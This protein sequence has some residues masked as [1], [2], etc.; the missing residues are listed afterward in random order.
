MII[1]TRLKGKFTLCL[2]R[3]FAWYFIITL[4]HNKDHVSSMIFFKQKGY[5]HMG[6]NQLCFIA[7]GFFFGC[8]HLSRVTLEVRLLPNVGLSV[9][10][11]ESSSVSAKANSFCSFVGATL[12]SEFSLIVMNN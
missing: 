4:S 12:F 2:L 10:L 5:S 1:L 3:P 9:G 6:A 7:L 8:P 11:G